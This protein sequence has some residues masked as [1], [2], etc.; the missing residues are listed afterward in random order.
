MDADS[1]PE[2]MVFPP[3]SNQ[4]ACFER[5]RQ[6]T[7]WGFLMEQGTGKSKSFCDKSIHLFLQEKIDA[8]VVIAP[9]GVH[10]NWIEIEVPTHMARV[11]VVSFL[12]LSSK[13]GTKKFMA[14]AEAF[15]QE[16]AP[17]IGGKR[18][19][20]VLAV[21]TETFQR[22]GSKAFTYLCRFM[23]AHRT[24]LGV[25]ESS[26]IKTWSATRSREVRKLRKFATARGIMTGTPVTTGPINFFSQFEFLKEGAL[27]FSS[28][29][30]FKAYHAEWREERHPGGGFM[31]N[32]ATGK[33]DKAKTYPV[34]VKYRHLD[35]LLAK[36]SAMAHLA[37]KVDCLDL[38]D[39]IYIKRP[40][41]MTDEQAA[42]YRKVRNEVLIYLKEDR[43]LTIM[44]ALS[45]MMRLSQVSGGFIPS[46]QEK[47]ALPIPGENAKL[48]SSL[49]I[50]DEMGPDDKL[51]IWARFIPELEMISRVLED[52]WPGRVAR[53]WGDIKEADRSSE[54]DEFQDGNRR[55]FVGQQHSGGYGITLTAANHVVY[56]SNSFSLEARLQSEDR[57]HRI[58]QKRNVTYYDLLATGTID[59]KVMAVLRAQQDL[60]DIFKKP[61]EIISWLEDDEI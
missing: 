32:P 11:P 33:R 40:V 58:G 20:K 53:W 8:M 30:A 60:A 54:K 31:Y 17:R 2:W 1:I 50:I 29:T 26:Q 6:K 18:A 49:S 61:A 21:N 39:K 12:W 57:A 56:Y 4:A 55:F 41:E 52:N 13:T 45:R 36:V 7:A 35:E 5:G 23:R 25:D 24:H 28:Y 3:F 9:N 10:R 48:Q 19:I 22:K 37:R 51:I 14:D 15:L 47:K 34:L 44:H 38:P 42:L 59:H 16:K 46:D 43:T 27:G